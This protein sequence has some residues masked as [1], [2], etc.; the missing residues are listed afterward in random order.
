MWSFLLEGVQ[1]LVARIYSGSNLHS[2]Q[3]APL[4]AKSIKF[5]VPRDTCLHGGHGLGSLLVWPP[6]GC[7]LYTEPSTF[8]LVLNGHCQTIS[9]ER[10]Q[11]GLLLLS[12]CCTMH[13]SCTGSLLLLFWLCSPYPWR[14]YQG[15]A[16]RLSQLHQL[17]PASCSL[18][19]KPVVRPSQLHTMALGW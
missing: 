13:N 14:V 4:K 16:L 12:H 19:V 3:A 10:F 7:C 15:I 9:S 2:I 11:Q 5:I 8:V 6:D 18:G 17:S 1:R